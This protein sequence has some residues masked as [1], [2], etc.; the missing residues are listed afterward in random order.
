VANVSN[1]KRIISIIFFAFITFGVQAQFIE[2]FTD[3]GFNAN[4]NWN[5][6]E[7]DFIVNTEKKLTLNVANDDGVAYLSTENKLKE[8]LSFGFYL[9]LD[10]K[11]SINDFVRIYLMSSV[12]DLTQ[13][14]EAYL[15]QI[16]ENHNLQFVK[17]EGN[18]FT[19]LK[20]MLDSKIID[21]IETN[22]KVEKIGTCKWIFSYKSKEDIDYIKI[23]SLI[24]MSELDNNY[25]GFLFNYSALSKANF[26][27]D[28]VFVEGIDRPT[29]TSDTL[30][31]KKIVATENAINL[32]LKN[33][34]KDNEVVNQ[35]NRFLID[36][37][38]NIASIDVI[39]ATTLRL[40]PST[41]LEK[42]KIYQ[43]N[44]KHIELCSNDEKLNDSLLF[45][46]T[47]V[48]QKQD[49]VINEVMFNTSKAEYIEFY[50]NTNKLFQLRDL[51]FAKASTITQTETDEINFSNENYFILPNDYFVFTR[52]K[53]DLSNNFTTANTEKLIETDLPTLDDE[54]DIVILKNIENKDVDRFKYNTSL[55]SSLLDNTKDVSLERIN[56]NT[57]TQ[58]KNNWYSASKMVGYAT[59]TQKNSAELN[60]NLDNIKVEPEVFSPD[61]DGYNDILTLTYKFDEPASVANLHIYNTEGRIVKTI[62]KDEILQEKGF[63]IWD[64]TDSN[65]NK[66]SV[67]IYFIILDV[68]ETN[69]RK[70]IFKEKCVLATPLN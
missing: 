28:D 37:I 62:L 4:P 40:T 61:Q 68:V 54:E 7:N 70:T 49:I 17:Q 3:G 16:N 43:L 31:I 8:N 63:F 42:N 64:G 5:G 13:E 9:K 39:N 45:A 32:E 59:P 27:I 35:T 25:F 12:E 69:G 47:D 52:S 65:G 15:L 2:Q 38:E 10:F 18:R 36:G 53:E 56:A 14:K 20:S 48:P 44:I 51:L 19:V 67:G 21:G 66:A 55:H 60:L 24:E 34:I 46:F 41:P 11:P 58:D 57:K 23:D 29:Q 30:K 6:T 33:K 50:N 26:Y 22:I 1:I